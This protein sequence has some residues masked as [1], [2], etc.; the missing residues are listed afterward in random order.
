MSPS[1]LY[2]GQLTQCLVFGF[3]CSAAFL[4]PTVC[5]I[6]SFEMFIYR[7]IN[8]CPVRNITSIFLGNAVRPIDSSCVFLQ[9]SYPRMS[10]VG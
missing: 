2:M 9:L 3:L 7:P 8:A 10:Y 4:L 6:L 5:A 1:Y